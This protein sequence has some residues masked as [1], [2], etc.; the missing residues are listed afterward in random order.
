MEMTNTRVGR[1]LKWSD[2]IG[3]TQIV[4]AHIA[5]VVWV[6]AQGGWFALSRI[7]PLTYEPYMGGIV[8][9]VFSAFVVFWVP[10]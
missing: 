5:F 10:D 7:G 2:P 8:A 1:G 9:I 6:F 4:V 3:R